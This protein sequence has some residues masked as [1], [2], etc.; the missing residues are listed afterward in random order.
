MV[1]NFLTELPPAIKL[2]DIWGIFSYLLWGNADFCF[3]RRFLRPQMTA[4]HHEIHTLD[5]HLLF[6]NPEGTPY[7]GPYREAP[8]ET[9]TFFRL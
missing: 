1:L 2:V 6:Y 5:T 8:P 4:I 9:G 3:Y 7:N